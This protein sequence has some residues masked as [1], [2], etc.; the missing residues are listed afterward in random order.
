[1][2]AIIPRG[3][4]SQLLSLSRFV[5]T[6]IFLPLEMVVSDPNCAYDYDSVNRI[7]MIKNDFG[8]K[9]RFTLKDKDGNAVNLSGATAVNFE[10]AL[11]RAKNTVVFGGACTVTNPVQGICEYEVQSGDLSTGGGYIGE[12]SI[13]TGTSAEVSAQNLEITIV[14]DVG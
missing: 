13:I 1:M 10:A 3:R 4:E 14:E 8:F 2:V 9:I 7:R 11:Q 12:V 5:E 6:G